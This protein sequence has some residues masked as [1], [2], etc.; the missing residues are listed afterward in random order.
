M[1]FRSNNKKNMNSRFPTIK[2]YLSVTTRSR[3]CLVLLN[4]ECNAFYF[5]DD[6]SNTADNQN[7]VQLFCKALYSKPPQRHCNVL[8]NHEKFRLPMIGGQ[9]LFYGQ[10]KS[11]IDMKSFYWWETPPIDF[12]RHEKN[13]FPRCKP[14]E[15]NG[16]LLRT[17]QKILSC[18]NFLIGAQ[19]IPIDL[20][21]EKKFF[22][23]F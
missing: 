17:N 20:H 6:S 13:F 14:Q 8:D 9:Q 3:W 2:N 16:N 15:I 4:K 1:F 22:S 5:G 18:S 21:R 23:C 10:S 12:Q 19:K 7:N 11:V